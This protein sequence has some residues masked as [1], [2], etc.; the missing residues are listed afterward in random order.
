MLNKLCLPTVLII[1]KLSTYGY[2][3]K[4]LNSFSFLSINRES[5][6][7][8]ISFPRPNVQT[9][10]YTGDTRTI[11]KYCRC[12]ERNFLRKRN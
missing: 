12:V 6:F 1:L 4:K 7:K 3:W 10:I 2:N 11:E 5:E 9:A 8:R